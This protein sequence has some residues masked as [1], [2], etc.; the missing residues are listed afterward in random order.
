M[1]IGCQVPILLSLLLLRVCC[2]P[3]E[4]LFPCLLCHFV[5]LIQLVKREGAESPIAVMESTLLLAL[6][7]WYLVVP[8]A[9]KK[10]DG[11]FVCPETCPLLL[12]V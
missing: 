9:W 5:L 8:I 10:S 11:R 7:I 12:D 2:Y 6:E 1:A 3:K 4:L